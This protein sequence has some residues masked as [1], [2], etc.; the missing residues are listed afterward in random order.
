MATTLNVIKTITIR[1]TTEG[2]TEMEKQLGRVASQMD[3]VTVS[4]EQQERATLS[5]DKAV[6]NLQRRYDQEFRAQQELAKVQKTLDGAR[7]QGLITQQQ[8]NA[9]MQQ[10]IR[11]HN[12][13]TPAVTSHA[14][15][16]TEL[17]TAAT[18]V[19]SQLGPIGGILAGITGPALAVVA[20]F[21]LMKLAFEA[22]VSASLELSRRAGDLRDLS[23][24]VGLTTT[25]LQAL[26]IAGEDVGIS[27]E[28]IRTSTE[29]FAAS[30]GQIREGSGEAAKSLNDI[31]PA[32]LR[33]VQSADTVA[34]AF[35]VIVKALANMDKAQAALLSRQLFG[36]GGTGIIRLAEVIAAAGGID[37]FAASLNRLDLIS[38]KQ[39]KTLDDLGDAFNRN[40]RLAKQSLILV[41][42]EDVLASLERFSVLLIRLR[43]DIAAFGGE[44]GFKNFFANF[45]DQRVIEGLLAYMD[46]F[47]QLG[48]LI[49]SVAQIMKSFK[50]LNPF[51][52]EAQAAAKQMSAAWDQAG[53]SATKLRNMI[54]SL[55]TA[56]A[57]VTTGMDIEFN[58][59]KNLS[60]SADEVVT[61]LPK[62]ATGLKDTA[63][64][65]KDADLEFK[66]LLETMEATGK[67]TD[68]QVRIVE[69]LKIRYGEDIPAALRSTEAA[70]IQFNNRMKEAKDLTGDFLNTFIQGL[71]K[72]ESLTRSLSSA[73][74][75]LGAEIARTSTRALANQLI[76]GA[77]GGAGVTGAAGAGVTAASS[78]SLF[79]GIA[80]ALGLGA[81]V[82]SPL[83]GLAVGAGLSLLGQLFDDSKENAEEAAALQQQQLE[84]QRQQQRIAQLTQDATEATAVLLEATAGPQGEF[85]QRLNSINQAFVRAAQ[86]IRDLGGQADETTQQLV[87]ALN[88]LRADVFEGLQREINELQGRGWVNQ[89][90]DV[91][92]RFNEAAA[93]FTDTLGGITEEQVSTLAQFRHLA[94]QNIINENQLVGESFNELVASLGPLGD[95]LHEFVA[96]LDET[97]VALNETA[98]AARDV[99]STVRE[100]TARQ[101]AADFAAGG[102]RGSLEERLML[103]DVQAQTQREQEIAA[104]GQ[105]LARLE[106]V[107]A[108]ERIAII[109]EFNDNVIEEQQRSEQE[110]LDTIRRANQQ[111]A[112]YLNGLLTGA[113][114][115]LSPRARLLRAQAEFNQQLLLAQGG[116]LEALQGITTVAETLRTA[117]QA[118]YGS[119]RAYVDIFNSI[120]GQLSTLAGGGGSGVFQSGGWVTGGSPGRDSVPLLAMPGEY[121]VRRQ[122]AQ[123]NAGNLMQLNTTGRWG[124]NDNI[125]SLLVMI[126][127]KLDRNTMATLAQTRELNREV[128]F[129]ERKQ[130]AV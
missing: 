31:S 27:L 108:T 100:L 35:D 114:S 29:R 106:Q 113:G 103:F 85:N 42:A 70:Q 118:F 84:I 81:N 95:G 86:A 58:P 25:Q 102:I 76:G 96:T 120:Q 78:G 124:A 30:L 51:G 32:L 40:M 89:V 116:N 67:L 2:V 117:A 48:L 28:N 87:N 6:M 123:S 119:S 7:A 74:Q 61:K 128:R 105:E 5:L 93:I 46:L 38:G 72:G 23:G 94:I 115:P 11:S 47:R 111:I 101:I 75:N 26:E 43:N 21:E 90:A 82:G 41:F 36:R 129:S 39:L 104:G 56:T 91:M 110:R 98:V 97:A 80:G 68:E 15:A 65:A 33:A 14:K 130:K 60:K 19:A 44:Q 13:A 53:E 22:T 50:D 24:T 20:A 54:V 45:I 127:E 64:A 99:T 88:R 12:T 17:R 92:K 73:M 8:A 9:L 16:L 3:K 69:R 37:Q 66:L 55:A 34:Q 4:S 126:G 71:I 125:A 10:A 83:V 63:G 1:G 57:D 109:R 121:I 62:V 18:G 59:W 122:V 49:L 79:G 52:P 77:A 112:D 107:L